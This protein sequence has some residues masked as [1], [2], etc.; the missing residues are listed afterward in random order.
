MILAD[1][2]IMLR[3]KNGWSQ[4]ELAEK[5]DV[6]RQSVSKW[7]GGLSVPDLNKIIAMS[8]LFGV[9]TDY[10]LKDSIEEITPSES[11]ESDDVTPT[12]SISAEEANR[13]LDTVKKSALRIALGVMLCIWSPICLILLP[14]LGEAG[15]LGELQMGVAVCLGFVALFLLVGAAVAIFIPTGMTLSEFAYL[16]TERISLEYGVKG[17]A[18]KKRDAYKPRFVTLLTLGVLLCIFSVVPLLVFGAMEAADHILIVCLCLLFLICS[19]GVFLIVQAGMEYDSFQKLLQTG[20]YVKKKKR[21]TAQNAAD[22][23]Y[24]SVITAIYLG[25]SFWTYDWH[26]TWIIWVVAGCLSP[27]FDCIVKRFTRNR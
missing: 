18:E 6:S 16:E 22:S 1:K 11:R 5:L 17:I 19:L 14:S 10:L 24:W 23:M 12:R 8:S 9:S 25:V 7:E 4:E 13:Y 2:I 21:N 27:V 20:D 15:L 3:K 26:R